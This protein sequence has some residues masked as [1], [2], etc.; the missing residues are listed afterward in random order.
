MV[1][2]RYFSFPIRFCLLGVL[3]LENICEINREIF[4]E[5]KH[6]S[7][8][9]IASQEKN[10][11]NNEMASKFLMIKKNIST[12]YY[13]TLDK[14]T[15]TWSYQKYSFCSRRAVLE[16]Y[17]ATKHCNWRQWQSSTNNPGCRSSIHNCF[18]GWLSQWY[19]MLCWLLWKQIF[20][21]WHAWCQTSPCPEDIVLPSNHLSK[22]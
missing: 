1:F 3:D 12:W 10:C 22:Y 4:E 5:F 7:D 8:W 18:L 20:K 2:F 19:L 17:I 13:I 11:W 15:E 9:E 16:Q 6:C 14:I 21:N